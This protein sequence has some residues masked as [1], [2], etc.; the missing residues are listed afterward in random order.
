MVS[1][2][3][4]IFIVGGYVLYNFLFLRQKKGFETVLVKQTKS[5]L[6]KNS[7]LNQSEKY[8]YANPD[9]KSGFH[10]LPVKIKSVF[11][12]KEQ[13]AIENGTL[14]KDEDIRANKKNDVSKN[15]IEMLKEKIK[16]PYYFALLNWKFGGSNNN[17]LMISFQVYN[18]TN[19]NYS[20]LVKIKC[21]TMDQSNNKLKEAEDE[22][23]IAVGANSKRIYK[24]EIVGMV[25]PFNVKKVNC[26]FIYLQN[27]K[28]TSN[29]KENVKSINISTDKNQNISR[30]KGEE[31]FQPPLNLFQQ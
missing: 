15:E 10:R 24:N 6:K 9:I 28:E 18:L 8:K 17:V 5:F 22:I 31:N 23:F 21:Y 13:K 12:K 16:E 7:D 3:F 4:L 2:V 29:V 27:N 30:G 14:Y 19:R 25:S 1:L 26:D 11:S 20:D